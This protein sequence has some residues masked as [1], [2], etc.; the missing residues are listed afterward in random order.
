MKRLL[1]TMA[2]VAGAA[3]ASGGPAKASLIADGLTY[4]LEMQSTSNPLIENF[5]LTIT[6]ENTANDTEGGGRTALEAFAFTAPAN[7]VAT[8]AVTSPSGYTFEQ[9]GLSNSGGTGDCDMKGT[10]F[11]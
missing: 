6:G 3:L 11:F 1:I 4:T 8:A 2:I 7:G 10:A 9:G 5:A